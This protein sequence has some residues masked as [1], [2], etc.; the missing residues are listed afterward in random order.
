MRWLLVVLTLLCALLAAWSGVMRWSNGRLVDDAHRMGRDNFQLALATFRRDYEQQRLTIYSLRE[1]A[2]Q[3]DLGDYT[4]DILPGRT[5]AIDEE[6]GQR[7]LELG[8][9]AQHANASV[10]MLACKMIADGD[11]DGHRLLQF[12]KQVDPHGWTD[13]SLEQLGELEADSEWVRA[14]VDQWEWRMER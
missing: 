5:S 2:A 14:E 1:G 9:M 12:L 4:I 8:N 7:W 11:P 6:S 3:V 13:A 10:V